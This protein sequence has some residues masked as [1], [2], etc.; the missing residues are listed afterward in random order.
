[1]ANKS[2]ALDFLKLAASGH[3]DEAYAS[4]TE[5]GTRVAHG[6]L[7]LSLLGGRSPLQ[8]LHHIR[9]YDARP[10]QIESLVGSTALALGGRVFHGFGSDNITFPGA[11]WL[12][13]H[14]VYG[15]ALTQ[16]ALVA[17]VLWWSTRGRRRPLVPLC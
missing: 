17:A 14:W 8:I 10:I 9:H 12:G 15:M 11:E 5:F 3:V 6:L 1:M 13:S 4:T 2:T 16:I 7:G